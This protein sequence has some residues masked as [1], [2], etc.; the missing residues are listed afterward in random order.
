MKFHEEVEIRNIIILTFD[1]LWEW[2]PHLCIN[3]V[4]MLKERL[5][6]MGCIISSAFC[7]LTWNTSSCNWLC[8]SS[9]CY[10]LVVTLLWLVD[11][12]SRLLR[13]CRGMAQH[14]N[15]RK[16]LPYITH[17]YL[18]V[19][20]INNTNFRCEWLYYSVLFHFFLATTLIHVYHLMWKW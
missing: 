4:I 1:L 20:T 8:S 9:L 14:P 13:G 17:W 6:K 5:N 15:E 11:I 19:L 2:S 18:L 16:C 10:Y 7:L 3:A 12:G